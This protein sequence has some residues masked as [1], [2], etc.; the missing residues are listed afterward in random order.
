[1]VKDSL[2]VHG[3]KETR[4][5]DYTAA[6]VQALLED[7]AYCHIPRGY[8]LEGKISKLKRLLYGLRQS[9]KNFFEHLKEK[10]ESLGFKQSSAVPC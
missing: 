5:V 6:F 3:I 1:M 8:R 2:I 9:P 10:L 7:E 4:Q